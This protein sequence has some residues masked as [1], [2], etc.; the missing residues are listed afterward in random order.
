MNETI[1]QSFKATGYGMSG[2]FLVLILFYLL[3][4]LMLLVFRNHSSDKE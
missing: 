3:T 2:V 4:K 1:I